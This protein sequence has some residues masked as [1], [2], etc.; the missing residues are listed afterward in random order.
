MLENGKMKLE[1][2]RFMTHFLPPASDQNKAEFQIYILNIVEK[3][4]RADV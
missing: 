4:P 1:E 2:I 3:L